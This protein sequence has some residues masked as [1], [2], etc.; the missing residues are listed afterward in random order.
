MERLLTIK[1]IAIELGISISTVSRALRGQPDVNAETRKAVVDLAEKLDYQP[2]KAALSLLNKHTNT[3]GVLVPNL[4]YFFATAIKGIDEAALEAGYTVMVCQSN[5]SYGKELINTKRLLESRVDGFIISVSSDT[6]IVDHF[7]KIQD[8]GI[9]M[10]FFDR[11][12]NELQAPKI[13]LNN[14]EG[15]YIA[16]KHLINKGYSKIAFL[17]GPERMSISNQ[18]FEGYK[19]A[20][21]EAGI[22]FNVKFVEHGDFNQEYA[23]VNTNELLRAK[24]KPD[25]I[26]AMSDRLAIGAMQSIKKHGLRIPDDIGLIGFNNEPITNLLSPSISTID[27][28]AFE[29]GKTAARLFIEM[30]NND[31]TASSDNIV[32]KPKL[33]VRES[34]MRK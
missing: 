34:T 5:E 20:L 10:V 11:D 16:T 4:D 17:G 15:G 26:F 14:F 9:P 12:V 32:L 28:P 7:K 6:K 23:Y 21:K 8:K 13:L 31:S 22:K 33:I 29:M 19:S 24:Q 3:I 1:D 2:N 18:R 27:Q 30:M 25:A